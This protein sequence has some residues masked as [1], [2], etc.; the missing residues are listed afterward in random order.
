MQKV[1]TFAFFSFILLGIV[2]FFKKGALPTP[3]EI[4]SELLASPRQT[5]TSRQPFQFAYRGTRYDVKPVADY[6][7]RA[8]VVTHNNITGLG[9]MYHDRDSVDTKDLCMVW[10]D[11]LKSEDYRKLKYR[12]G[13]WTCYYS[14]P[15]VVKFHHNQL[16]NNHLITDDN[17]I[18]KRIGQV[19]IG[20]QIHVAGM[21]VNYRDAR[22]PNYWRTSSTTRDD[23]GGR[24][25]EVLFVEKIEILKQQTPGWHALFNI[26]LWM[27]FLIPLVKFTFFMIEASQLKEIES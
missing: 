12:S 7:I 22:H 17:E 26:S 3:S 13:S 8:V 18:R 6:D 21:L 1:L 10:G 11:N 4:H 14:F 2:S 9:D 27:V 23:Q 16:S 5:E 24:A 15:G 19:R 25:C 20:D